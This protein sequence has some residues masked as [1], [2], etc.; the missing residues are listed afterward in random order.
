MPLYSKK[1]LPKA[2]QGASTALLCTH[3]A[4][5]LLLFI[6]GGSDELRLGIPRLSWR[7]DDA[8]AP[9]LER[10]QKGLTNSLTPER[11][12]YE[13]PAVRPVPLIGAFVALASAC[14][15]YKPSWGHAVRRT[16]SVFVVY[17]LGGIVDV[18]EIFLASVLALA[19]KGVASEFAVWVPPIGALVWGTTGG[20]DLYLVLIA[21]VVACISAMSHAIDERSELF[22]AALGIFY[23][24]AFCV[25]ETFSGFRWVS[26][27]C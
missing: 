18:P 9:P 5:A 1:T 24:M 26:P 19:S 7:W 6:L 22:G 15:L 20:G 21:C 3:G 14:S 10:T 27:H 4:V 12:C 16:C 8:R 11:T 17:I 25:L 13:L 23:V 2:R